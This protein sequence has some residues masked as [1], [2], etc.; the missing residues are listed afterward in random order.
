MLSTR[1]ARD[2][3]N[4]RRH[5][6]SGSTSTCG[7]RSPTAPAG[8]APSSLPRSRAEAAELAALVTSGRLTHSLIL[9]EDAW[10]AVV[11]ERARKAMGTES[12][13]LG[14]PLPALRTHDDTHGT[15]F[16]PTLAAW[17]DH[18]GDPKGTAQALDVH[19]N[20]LRYRLRRMTEVTPLDLSS[21]QTR[22]A[23]R[24]QLNALHNHASRV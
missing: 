7:T 2:R 24:L 10:D 3:G 1:L 12:G 15:A 20:T 8:T 18:Y 21:P 16:L 6:A 11:V 4:R 19:P 14:G 22:L 9:L 23:L 17:L 5:R 13:L